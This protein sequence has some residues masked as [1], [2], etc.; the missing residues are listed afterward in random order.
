MQACSSSVCDVHCTLLI[1]Q[2]R[3]QVVCG[4]KGG[5]LQVC[6]RFGGPEAAQEHD[7]RQQA[8]IAW[9]H[10]VDSGR[11]LCTKVDQHNKLGMVP[12]LRPLQVSVLTLYRVCTFVT[13]RFLWTGT[14]SGRC[15]SPKANNSWCGVFASAFP[16][17]LA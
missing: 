6:H 14:H 2:E 12:V 15:F 1:W 5:V 3:P 9:R 17:L 8:A 7:R 10:I 11:A 13:Q 4:H 16:R